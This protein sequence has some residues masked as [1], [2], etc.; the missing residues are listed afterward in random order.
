MRNSIG[1]ASRKLLLPS[2][3]M[4]VLLSA[5]LACYAPWQKA[6]VEKTAM[7]QLVVLEKSVYV[8]PDAILLAE[9]WTSRQGNVD[10]GAGLSRIYL[11]S[12]SC[13][14]LI[15]DYQKAMEGV[16]WTG[17]S[18]GCDRE[19]WLRM[20]TVHGGIIIKVAPSEKSPDAELWQDLQEQHEGEG[21]MYYMIVNVVLDYAE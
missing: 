14:E 2:I 3:A 17:S 10:A 12:Q 16:G 19:I 1:Q 7:A 6:Q 4:F 13:E 20:V 8:P 15:A 18:D 9:S 11:T 21:L 5:V